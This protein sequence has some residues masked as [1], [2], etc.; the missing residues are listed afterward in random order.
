[1]IALSQPVR[2][3]GERPKEADDVKCRRNGCQDRER[4]SN[5][6]TGSKLTFDIVNKH[7][8]DTVG[9]DIESGHK[10]IRV[11]HA[12]VGKH[13]VPCNTEHQNNRDVCRDHL[14]REPRQPAQAVFHDALRPASLAGVNR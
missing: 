2:C 4:Q 3:P 7:G 8:M 14:K 10:T 6:D 12:L 11:D 9:L 13:P 1:M 5:R